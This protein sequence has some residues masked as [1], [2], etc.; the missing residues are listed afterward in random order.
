M[1]RVLRSK[2]KDNGSD[3]DQAIEQAAANLAEQV[4]ALESEGWTMLGGIQT[5]SRQKPDGLMIWLM[6]AM[7]KAEES[8]TEDRV[9]RT[10]MDGPGPDDFH[11]VRDT[12]ADE[13]VPP[14]SESSPSS[15]ADSLNP[16]IGTPEGDAKLQEILGS[17]ANLNNP[18]SHG[19]EPRRR[20][21]PP[22]SKNQR[23]GDESPSLVDLVEQV[24]ES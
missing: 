5:F 13:T 7:G 8:A 24:R 19:L 4:E 20:G 9:K 22:G 15:P 3:P 6:Q 12:P 23:S 14:E 10:M 11:V 21:R 16:W 18:P 2:W 1:Y 17:P